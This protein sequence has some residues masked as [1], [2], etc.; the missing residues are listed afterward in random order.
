MNQIEKL[1]KNKEYEKLEKFLF[2]KEQKDVKN[3]IYWNKSY[4]FTFIYENLAFIEKIFE[5]KNN[6]QL[7]KKISL[8]LWLFYQHSFQGIIS[9]SKEEI[10]NKYDIEKSS[11]FAKKCLKY[12]KVYWK[13]IN[14]KNIFPLLMVEFVKKDLKGFERILDENK[15]RDKVWTSRQ[16]LIKNMTGKLIGRF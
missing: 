1:Y 7:H 14:Q 2:D 10:R 8:I 4:K 13:G 6:K 5:K 16:K 3:K 12:Y 9:N 15:N 11:Y